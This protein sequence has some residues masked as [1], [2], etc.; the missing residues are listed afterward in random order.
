MLLKSI[1][2]NFTDGE[3]IGKG[4][5]SYSSPH[6]STPKYEISAQE[7]V[8]RQEEI[9]RDISSDLLKSY[10]EKTKVL[11]NDNTLSSLFF[12]RHISTQEEEK[13][14]EEIVTKNERMIREKWIKGAKK[15]KKFKK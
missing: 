11:E 10:T 13:Q 3:K 7:I 12:S 14:A 9:A 2:N 15:K 6:S 1:A 5:S 4:E 8:S